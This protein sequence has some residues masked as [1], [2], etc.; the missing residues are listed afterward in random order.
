MVVQWQVAAS[1]QA[2]R[3]GSLDFAQAHPGP[4]RRR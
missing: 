4:L 3:P 1:M 2:R